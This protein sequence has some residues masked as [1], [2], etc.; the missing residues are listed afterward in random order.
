MFNVSVET[1]KKGTLH[2]TAQQSPS[3]F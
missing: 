2:S 1:K 3:H